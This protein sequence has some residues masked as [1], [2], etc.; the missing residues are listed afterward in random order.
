MKQKIN[1]LCIVL[2]ASFALVSEADR[3]WLPTAGGNYEWQNAA[4]WSDGVVAG[5]VSSDQA[6]MR[7]TG[8]TGGDQTINLSLAVNL[9][10]FYPGSFD[11]SPYAQIFTGESISPS[12]N[13]R[14]MGGNAVFENTVNLSGGDHY[15]G[16]VFKAGL[17][18]RESGLLSLANGAHLSVGRRFST[19][20]P[21]GPGAL[22]IDD[23]ATFRMRGSGHFVV[24]YNTISGT[25]LSP[26]KVWQSG[27]LFDAEAYWRLGVNADGYYRLDGGTVELP[28]LTVQ[29]HRVG[30]GAPKYA[31]LHISDGTFNLSGSTMQFD[32]G[33]QTASTTAPAYSEVYLDGGVLNASYRPIVIASWITGASDTIPHEATLTVNG[34]AKLYARNIGLGNTASPAARAVLNLNGGLCSLSYYLSV[35]GGANNQAFLNFN[36]GTLQW[37]SGPGT[38]SNSPLGSTPYDI[39][40]YGDGG[41]LDTTYTTIMTDKPFRSAKGYGVESVNLS[42]G[43]SDYGAAPRVVLSG[44][45]GSNATAVAIMNRDGS[46]ERVA[47]TCPGEGYLVG[48]T[49]TASFQTSSGYGSGASASV[50]LAENTPGTF[51][52]MGGGTWQVTQPN[53]FDSTVHMTDGY[54]NLTGSG[55]FP[56]LS[57]LKLTGG[58]FQPSSNLN[59]RVNSE[60]VLE[61]AGGGYEPFYRSVLPDSGL[62]NTQHFAALNG[63]PGL[64]GFQSTGGSGTSELFFDDY[65][66]TGSMIGFTPTSSNR[67]WLADDVL[68]NGSPISPSSVS[69]VV[70][71]FMTADGLNLLERDPVSGNLQIAS[72][73]DVAN[74]DANFL[75]PGGV[76]NVSDTTVNSVV[77]DN[78]SNNAEVYFQTSGEVELQSGMILSRSRL[79]TVKRV[80]TLAGGTL[81]TEVPGGMV[82]YDR[83]SND[84]REISGYGG[85]YLISTSLADPAPATPMAVTIAGGRFSSVSGSLVRFMEDNT[86]SGGLY[87]ANGGL[88]YDGDAM[89]GAAGSPVIA[90]G[91]CALRP[92]GSVLETAAD[93]PIEIRE[94]SSLQLLGTAGDCQVASRILYGGFSAYGGDLTVNLHGDGRTLEWG[95]AG[96]PSGSVLYLQ[97]RMANNELT[98]MNGI[99]L[100]GL[101]TPHIRVSTDLEKIAHFT[102]VISDS[103]GGGTLIKGGQGILILEQSPT[104]DGT[105]SILSGTVRLA[106]GVSLN[107]LSEVSIT[108]DGKALEVMGTQDVQNVTCKITGT[109]SVTVSDGGTTVMSGT[110]TY[111]GTTVVANE[112]TLLV[113][114]EHN[115][116]GDYDVTGTLGGTGVIAPAAGSTI[117]FGPGSVISPAGPGAIGTL[118]LGSAATTN[119]VALS[120]TTLEIDLDTVS[121]DKLVVAGDLNIS[122]SSSVNLLSTDE[123]LLASLRGT[124]I[125]I[126]EW[127]GDKAGSFIANTN[128]EGW[129][130]IEN[131]SAKTIAL[132]YL[133]PGTVILLR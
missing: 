33:S 52:K 91:Y 56:D 74:A 95:S 118:T 109:G 31:F 76:T 110:N 93:R 71:G 45:S 54:L 121:A 9:D 86:F 115:G 125:T 37:R 79:G 4:N 34:D 89:L 112:S 77:F 70:A 27:G 127:T 85:R 67:L 98:F 80:G 119:T 29:S 64:A 49:L 1:V 132:S 116:G 124:A 50:T 62:T 5:T 81:T 51:T 88:W 58:V 69:P 105:L 114:G 36:G 75:V 16:F 25:T 92:S 63:Q 35:F 53:T 117:T 3:T 28:A 129:K 47:V 106:Q 87:L 17:T 99:D 97:N 90:S 46:V 101:Q 23:D 61:L 122:G 82:I 11:V 15:I 43:G 120:N 8:Q 48:D 39:A 108:G 78:L 14:V 38:G 10:S 21:G 123:G 41:T 130:V 73:T 32:L 100:N 102:G 65:N 22:F 83:E 131:L 30:E 59:D 72:L 128:V 13:F 84:R 18:L 107:T 20:Y 96:L 12:T 94:N 66:R 104:F 40:I 6:Q 126:C 103:V 24:A 57:V 42:I 68:T 55:S 7:T 26:G 2:V 133:S 113:N 60:A 19:S 111:S 44:G